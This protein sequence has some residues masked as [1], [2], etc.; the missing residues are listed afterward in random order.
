MWSLYYSAH[1][2]RPFQEDCELFAPLFIGELSHSDWGV[3]LTFPSSP[4]SLAISAISANSKICA[5]IALCAHTFQLSLSLIINGLNNKSPS[6]HGLPADTFSYPFIPPQKVR[7][8][9]P[10]DYF[11]L[12]INAPFLI[13]KSGIIDIIGTF[14]NAKNATILLGLYTCW[15]L[16]SLSVLFCSPN[17]A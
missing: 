11:S 17:A 13:T 4:L 3:H 15:H 7:R 12:K 8:N 1:S 2:S 9:S 6:S 10:Q 5:E 16:L 14:N